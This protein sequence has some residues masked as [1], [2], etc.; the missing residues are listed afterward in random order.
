MPALAATTSRERTRG[1][2][3]QLFLARA[4]LRAA[5][6]VKRTAAGTANV[7]SA[8]KPRRDDGAEAKYSH[9]HRQVQQQVLQ[10]RYFSRKLF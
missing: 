8:S 9:Q 10:A 6:G 1:A 7:H 3:P 4:T 5:P 2:S